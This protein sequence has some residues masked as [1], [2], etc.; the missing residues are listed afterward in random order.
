[1]D[2]QGKKRPKWQEEDSLNIE[3]KLLD[4]RNKKKSKKREKTKTKTIKPDSTI[5]G[6][7]KPSLVDSHP[8]LL[9]PPNIAIRSCRSIT[10]YQKI[11]DIC[12]GAY[13]AVFSAEEVA[14]RARFALKRIKI[15][16][17]DNHGLPV[18]CL[19]EI[20]ILNRLR[21]KNVVALR[22]V[23]VEE[24]LLSVYIV[25]EYVPYD[26]YHCLKQGIRFT[27][28]EIKSILHQLLAAVDYIHSQRILHRDLKPANILLTST[29][30]LKVADFGLAR[31][32]APQMTPSVVTLWYRSP[33]ILLGATC[34]SYTVDYWAVGCIFSELVTLEP[35]FEASSEIQ[36]I[37][38]IFKIIGYPNKNTWPGFHNL[39]SSRMIKIVSSISPGS[40]VTKYPSL[41][42]SGIDLLSQLLTLDP[43]LRRGSTSH[44]YF[45]EQPLQ[46]QPSLNE[47]FNKNI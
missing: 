20:S 34:Y 23:V 33:E 19:R 16:R 6:E 44:A 42:P 11:Q 39:P 2:Q 37:H 28:P 9:T 13:G 14:T 45:Q 22:E 15:H 26:L 41:S 43:Q 10:E 5:V 31:K 38:K 40:L 32:M 8:G 36:V 35:L 30:I 3:T 24:D 25:M 4:F 21:H 27:V 47:L 46:R 29:G 18:T 1:M 17:P 7:H 12:E